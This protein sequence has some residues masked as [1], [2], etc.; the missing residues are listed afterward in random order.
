MKSKTIIK[1]NITNISL[2]SSRFSSLFVITLSLFLA[3]FLLFTSA[4]EIAFFT[5]IDHEVW[6]FK[7]TVSSDQ[8]EDQQQ[9]QEKQQEENVQQ[10]GNQ[11]GNS[12]SDVGNAIGNLFK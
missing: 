11:T 12:L 7:P 8:N 3:I 5:G 1:K 2:S 9:L 6:A 10:G 4:T